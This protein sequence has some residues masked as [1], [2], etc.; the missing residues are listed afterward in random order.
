MPIVKPAVNYRQTLDS[1][2][3][4]LAELMEER[5][6]LDERRETLHQRIVKLR[7]VAYGLASLCDVE[8]IDDEHPSLFPN[9]FSDNA[10]VGLTDAI[11][12]VLSS[13]EEAN[14]SPV[15]IRDRLA[16]VGFD[17]KTHKNILASIHT[18]LKRLQRQGEV[19]PHIREGRTS[20]KW[21][22]KKKE[23]TSELSDEDIPF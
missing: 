2:I 16:D 11:R 7:R 12:Q 19:T 17:I 4:E 8:N 15:F 13:H 14:L 3:K 23:E 18:V 1:A 21:V 6:K 10:D 22:A 20:Y 9:E 5:E